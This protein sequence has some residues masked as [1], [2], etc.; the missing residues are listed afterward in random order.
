MRPPAG[1]HTYEAASIML[2]YLV[3]IVIFLRSPTI[4]GLLRELR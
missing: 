4:Y 2:K 3:T 1:K